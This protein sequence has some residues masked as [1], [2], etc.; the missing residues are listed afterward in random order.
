VI[1]FSR[2]FLEPALAPQQ[3]F[4][5]W[6]QRT[7][8]ALL[9]GLA[10]LPLTA[11]PAGA[12]EGSNGTG[13]SV[14]RY[15]LVPVPMRA[16]SVNGQG[17]V[18]GTTK[19]FHA[20][21]WSARS[22]LTTIGLPAGFHHAEGIAV[23]AHGAV[24]GKAST[25]DG[26][27]QQSFLFQ[28]GKVTLVAGEPAKAEGINSAGDLAGETRQVAESAS[29]PALWRDGKPK[30]LGACCG[31]RATALNDQGDVVGEANDK[32]GRY[33]AFVW[34]RNRGLRLLGPR[35]IYSSAIAVNRSGHVLIYAFQQGSWI[36]REGHMVPLV[37]S[38]L[39]PSQ[40]RSI[41]DCDVVVGSFG[42]NSDE[43]HAFIWD[44]KGGFR[45]LNTLI[46]K[47][48]GWNLEVATSINDRG[49]I[50]G[51]GDNDHEDDAGFLLLPDAP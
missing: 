45:D 27:R 7:L 38:K 32:E 44:A 24:L 2:I 6:P 22:G 37:L 13:C 8:F 9:L 14:P 34:N 35:N 40:P 46:P 17:V 43:S 36:F 48:S 29:G 39:W 28:D 18:A 10:G 50:A 4:A 5:L 21:V 25:V 47:D 51:W 1:D 11:I 30:G 42:A 15:K 41:N 12:R 49:E 31:G 16:W 3:D 23:N 19:D 20:G 26:T 33:Q